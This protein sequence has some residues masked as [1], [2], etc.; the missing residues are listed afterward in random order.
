MWE[1]VELYLK[2]IQCNLHFSKGEQ[3]SRKGKKKHVQV[4]GPSYENDEAKY[5][6]FSLCL[7]K[8]NFDC[9]IF[10]ISKFSVSDLSYI[11]ERLRAHYSM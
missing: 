5:L 1:R 10:F 11:W 7:K 6:L 3:K 4:Q 9:E 2:S 8:N